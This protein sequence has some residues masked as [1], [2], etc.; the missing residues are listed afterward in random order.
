MKIMLIT[1]PIRPVPTSFPPIGSL[2]ILK[3][4]KKNGL[5]AEFYNIDARRPSYEEAIRHIIEAKPD[6]LGVSAVV[7]TAYLY[8]KHLTQDV[9]KALPNCLIVVGGNLSA[10]AEILLRRTGADLCAIGEGE[11]TFLK[12]C[13]RA[14]TS[15][16]PNDFIEIPGLALIDMADQMINTGYPASLDKA[17]VY[18]IDYADLEASADIG[19]FFMDVF[20]ESG[21]FP[22]FQT[23]P[24]TYEAHRH[25]KKV[26][27]L[28]AS[29]GCVARCTFCH[30]WD[31]G[32]RYIPVDRIMAQIE[33]AIERYNVGFIGFGDEN[34]GTDGRWLAEFCEAIAKYDILWHV[35]GMRVNCISEQ[36]IEM[37]KRAG[38]CSINYGMETGS[39]KMLQI[40]EKK[41]KLEDNINAMRWTVGA[42]LHTVVQLVLGM[43]GETTETVKETV[44]F[45]K[46]VL[47][48]DKSQNPN[49]LSINY[50]QALPGTPLY[51][52]GRHKNLIGSDLDAEESYLL[53][54]S[55]QNA[56]DADLNFTDEPE[57]VRFLWRPI[58]QLEV[59][60]E[61]VAK[62]G[63]AHYHHV[64][65]NDGNF[66]QRKVAQPSGY[67][68]VP[69][70]T[71]EEGAGNENQDTRLPGEKALVS[72][73]IHGRK[74]T[75]QLGDG[76]LVPSL[77]D[78]LKARKRHLAMIC[79]P[80]YFY[81]LRFLLL[82]ALL[83]ICLMRKQW[84]A[85]REFFVWR[86]SHSFDL[87]KFEEYKSLRKIVEKD[88][89]GYVNSTAAADTLRRG[90]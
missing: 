47:T 76:N 40:M 43:P 12:V 16:D 90:R 63:L 79:Y 33:V 86:V 18:D 81:R 87:K 34:F 19:L 50:A 55:D 53:E 35:G 73:T 56:T 14:K 58:I 28:P 64:L 44:D 27:V 31:K 49:D 21:A 78:L 41:T 83:T 9:K 68:N 46:Q 48:L 88:L 57:I 51:E 71:M 3:Y 11:R 10:S 80:H 7:S 4:L 23:D 22:W 89:G 74:E 54:I 38:C 62:F 65:S 69:K 26:T 25:D 5:E 42:G 59:L 8:T 82:P 1:T 2:S 39:P 84:G 15:R 6:V 36:Q 70:R 17:D 72:D 37:M 13:Q 61:Y 66:F 77:Y 67:Y 24:R 60:N 32:I 20:D 52:Y 30:R 29:K 85:L 45:C 75:L